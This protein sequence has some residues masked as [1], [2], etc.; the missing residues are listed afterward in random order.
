MH[1]NNKSSRQKIHKGTL[2]LNYPLDQMDLTDLYKTLHPTA[3]E[4]PCFSCTCRTFSND[5]SYIHKTSLCKFKKI[6][7]MSNI[8]SNYNNMKL[9]INK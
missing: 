7:I 8:F 1:F 9:E 4:N 5:R 6:E 3:A 2:D